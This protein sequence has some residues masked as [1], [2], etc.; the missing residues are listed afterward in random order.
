LFEIYKHNE[1]NELFKKSQIKVVLD[2]ISKLN[3][4][5]HSPTMF[6]RYLK[7]IKNNDLECFPLC[8]LSHKNIYQTYYKK[9]EEIIKDI[10]NQYKINNTLAI[11]NLSPL[12]SS[13]LIYLIDVFTNKRF[14]SITPTTIYNIVNSFEKKT[15]LKH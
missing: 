2:K 12:Y 5:K 11:Y 15:I 4:I 10:Q 9:I 14:H 3:I 7:T 8:D 1:N 13:I 6:Y